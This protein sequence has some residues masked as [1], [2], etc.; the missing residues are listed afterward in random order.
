[1]KATYWEVPWIWHGRTVAVL[2]SGPSMSQA[3]ADSV[4]H[5]PRIAVNTTY[6]LAPDADVLYA[7]DSKWWRANPEALACPGL[8]VALEPMPGEL[9]N[10]PPDVRVLR[11][12][13]GEGYDPRPGYLRTLSNSGGQAIQVAAKSGAAR[14]LLL[15]F[16]MHGGHWHEPHKLGNPRDKTYD[17]WISRMAGLALAMK[18]LGVEVLNCTPGSRLRCFPMRVL[19]DAIAE[20]VA[21]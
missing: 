5:L 9:P 17:R 11:N 21:A 13:G 15:G 8:K 12:S 19:E 4:R 3:V 16:D 1:M 6:Q 20:R 2:A 14:I 18:N 10:V 7:C